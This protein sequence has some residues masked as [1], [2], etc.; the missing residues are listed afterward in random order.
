MT[1]IAN[2]R[3]RLRRWVETAPMRLDLTDDILALLDANE[4]Q[5]KDFLPS[6]IDRLWKLSTTALKEQEKKP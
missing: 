4:P 6:E 3:K 5:P 2:V 1:D